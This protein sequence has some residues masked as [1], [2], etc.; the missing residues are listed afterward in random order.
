MA[1]LPCLWQQALEPTVNRSR[2][3]RNLAGPSAKKIERKSMAKQWL[4]RA[5][6][7]HLG[8]TQ[9]QLGSA[10]G[11][12]QTRVSEMETGKYSP[13]RLERERFAKKVAAL[14]AAR[15]MRIEA[16]RLERS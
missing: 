16:T 12:P 10:L 1:S 15:A 9:E 13:T 3:D 14:A 6:R 2:R 5:M 11:V 7:H 4:L 8:F